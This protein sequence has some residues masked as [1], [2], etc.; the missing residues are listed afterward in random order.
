MKRIFAI[1][2]LAIHLFYIG[3][4]SFL[5][6]YY[7]HRSD[8]RLVK[9]IFDNKVDNNRFVELKIPVHMPTI[10]DWSDYEV[11][12]GQIQLKNYYYNYVRLRMTRD[13][14]YFV[15]VPDTVKTR[16]EK[17]KT[18]AA[19]EVND[20]SA[21]K[22]NHNAPVKK[23]NSLGDYNMLA[24]GFSFPQIIANGIVSKVKFHSL[25]LNDPYIKSPGKPPNF[26]S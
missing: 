12:E 7:I 10:Q 8:A 3:G 20:V 25:S 23:L 26:L 22:K 9:E 19:K 15:C 18:I 1:F 4:Y 14:M 24:A 16:L 17:A 21:S 13:T 2:L 11:I 5:Y 6:N